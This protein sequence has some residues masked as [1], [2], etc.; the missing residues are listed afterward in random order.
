MDLLRLIIIAITPGIALAMGLYLTDR[1]DREPVRLLLRLFLYGMLAAVPTIV[2]ERFF[3][4]RQYISRDFCPRPGQ[5][6]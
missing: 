3:K 4:Q 5:H 1:Y 6:I 2:V